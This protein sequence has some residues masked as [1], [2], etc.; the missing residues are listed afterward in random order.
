MWEYE[1]IFSTK[2]FILNSK[3]IALC[4]C[5]RSV[6]LSNIHTPELSTGEWRWLTHT[7]TYLCPPSISCAKTHIHLRGRL[8]LL[9]P[10]A[11]PLQLSTGDLVDHGTHTRTLT[12]A[13]LLATHMPL[14][15]LQERYPY[16]HAVLHAPSN[17]STTGGW[18]FLVEIVILQTVTWD[19][20]AWSS[21]FLVIIYFSWK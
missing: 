4:S 17:S 9:L 18:V 1:R 21:R 8:F 19:I 16:N 10:E 12:H 2:Y 15:R 3:I 5:N 13:W 11:L 6:V 7:H 20:R 14:S